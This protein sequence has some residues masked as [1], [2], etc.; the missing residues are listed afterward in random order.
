[1]VIGRSLILNQL[2][3]SNQMNQPIDKQTFIQD[4]CR[5]KDSKIFALSYKKTYINF[6][7]WTPPFNEH[8][9][10]IPDDI[11]SKSSFERTGNPQ[12]SMKLFS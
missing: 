11:Y 12:K 8:F 3:A 7:K 10:K 6:L 5:S 4:Q 2:N 1:M 9:S